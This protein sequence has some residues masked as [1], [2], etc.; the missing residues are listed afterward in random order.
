MMVMAA[1]RAMDVLV[2]MGMVV[3]MVVAAAA[4]MVMM[5]MRVAAANIGHGGRAL[6]Q[7]FDEFQPVG[8]LNILS[9]PSSTELI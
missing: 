2:L 7:L 1:A 4:V 9:S 6:E 8:H 5:V 3:R